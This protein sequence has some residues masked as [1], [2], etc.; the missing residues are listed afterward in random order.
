MKNI[1]TEITTEKI[2][3]KNEKTVIKI[4]EEFTKRQKS[5]KKTWKEIKLLYL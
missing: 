3:A 4:F 5:R 2:Q 1:Q